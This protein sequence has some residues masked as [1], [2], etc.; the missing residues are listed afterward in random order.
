MIHTLK[1]RIYSVTAVFMA[2]VAAAAFALPVFAGS[3]GADRKPEFSSFEEL[4]GRT[5][6]ML[7]GAPFEG[8]I[9]SKVP[10]VRE[11]TYYA[12]PTEMLLALR[13]GK[14][15]AFLNNTMIGDLYIN[16]N[17][18]ITYLP[19]MLKEAEF[20]FG[21]SKKYK[22]L[23]EWKKALAGIS[24]EEIQAIWDKWTGADD[25]KK[26]MPKQDWKGKAGKV[27]VA[28]GDSMQPACYINAD[29]DV[30]GMEA[31]I[32]LK[33]AK[34]LD[35]KVEFM[36]MEFAA[37]IASVESGKA[38]F[39]CGSIIITEERKKALHF[40]PY[41]ET[42]FA[43]IIRTE[44]EDGAVEPSGGLIDR[45]RDTLITDGRYKL[46]LSGLGTTLFVSVGSGL[47]G[48]LLAFGLVSLK[49]KNNQIINRL[50]AIYCRLVA[51]LPVV[52]ILM[53]LYYGAFGSSDISPIWVALL[54]FILIFTPKAYAL[55]ANAVD[56]VDGGQLE[57]ALALGYSDKLAYRRVILP[58]ARK[59]YFPLLKT[60]F[61]LLVK[62][63]SVVGYI[64]AVDLTR[65]GDIIRGHTLDA[66]LPVLIIA[67]IYFFLTWFIAAA[68]E[69]GT[70]LIN[71]MAERREAK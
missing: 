6:S 35:Y 42:A 63:T 67:V 49:R 54:G 40:L 18:D 60:Q 48:L 17:R 3:A 69:A 14:T 61:S 55:I 66:F 51:G 28:I 12:S 39:C 62:E 56:T 2:L 11:Y 16:K 33:M 31:E 65:A 64:A 10:D 26:T 30:L 21:F 27:R 9:S 52:V 20:G 34:E 8:L 36:P 47:I 19:E 23:S 58:Q 43:L 38:D 37:L 32:I 4:N 53:L 41:T 70:R 15:D 25:S 7:T 71:R 13:T 29:G 46:I 22:K 57:A 59:I 24:D 5:I 50:L 68:I 1:R 45:L 44:S